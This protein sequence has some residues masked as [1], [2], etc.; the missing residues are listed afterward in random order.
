MASGSPQ[1]DAEEGAAEQVD[2]ARGHA[3]ARE[4]PYFCLHFDARLDRM[5]LRAR[6][7]LVL[8]VRARAEGAR[9]LALGCVQGRRRPMVRHSARDSALRALSDNISAHRWRVRN[10]CMA[11]EP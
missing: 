11:F 7:L 3:A 9:I 10:V 4:A 8:F 6:G 1:S 5:V 2:E